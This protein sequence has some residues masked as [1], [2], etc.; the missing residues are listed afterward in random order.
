MFLRSIDPVTFAAHVLEFLL[1]AGLVVV[2]GLTAAFLVARSYVRRHWRLL[3]GHVAVRGILATLALVAA[4]RERYAGRAT[5]ED[6]SRGAAPRVRRRLRV[7]VEDAEIAVAHAESR[8]APVAELPAVCRSLQRVADELDGLLRLERRLPSGSSRADVRRQVAEV[9]GAARDVQ[10]AAV[11]AGS[12]ATEPQV[13]SL[14]R[15]ARDEVDIVA[16]RAGQLCGRRP[17]PTERLLRRRSSTPTAVPDGPARASAAPAKLNG[18]RPPLPPTRPSRRGHGP[19]RRPTEKAT[20]PASLLGD[21]F[22]VGVATSGYQV[23]GGFNGD[24][25]PHNNWAAWESAGKAARSGLACDF[26]RR[27]EEALDRAAAI[28][29]NAFRLSVEWARLEPQPG[30]FDAAALERYAEILSMC[31]ERGLEPIVTLHHFT[32]PFWLGEEFWL[33]PGS[34]DIF[35]R[36]VERVVPALAPYCRRWVTINEPNIVTLMGW[37]EGSCPPGRRMAVSDAFSALD[38]ILTAHVLAADVVTACSPRRR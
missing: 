19:R 3:H 24:G 31:V 1:I 33:R 25:E 15:H 2:L 26:W 36:H 14:V 7:A 18:C 30:A 4:G 16:T 21:G 38:N 28:G 6:L 32:H 34:P 20:E 37:I 35:A 9:I 29:C 8:D 5:P 13:R 17:V 11:R 12:D 27:P 22:A 10:A 23:E